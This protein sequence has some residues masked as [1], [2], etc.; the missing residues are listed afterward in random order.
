[1]SFLIP[2]VRLSELEVK[3][4]FSGGFGVPVVQ[5]LVHAGTGLEGKL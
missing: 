4:L 5:V 1:M 3:D 2:G